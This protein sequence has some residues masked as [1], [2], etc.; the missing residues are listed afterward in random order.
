MTT[1]TPRGVRANL[2]LRQ[3]EVGDEAALLKTQE[4]LTVAA[5]HA[6][7]RHRSG[8]LGLIIVL[9]LLG[10]SLA[11]PLL[12][13]HDPLAM[14]T[15][16]RFAPPSAQYPMGAD[17]FGRDIFSRL[18]YGGRVAFMVSSISIALATIVGVTL[19]AVAGYLQGWFD[20]VSMRVLDAI[21]AFPAILLAIVILAV[22]GPGILNAMLAVAIV[23]I[24]AFARLARANVLVEKH[25]EYVTAARAVGATSARILFRAI[26]PNSL[27]TI[28]VRVTVAF[29]G[30][31]LLESS[32]SFL[33]L[34]VP[35]PAPSWGSML[36]IGRTYMNYAPWYSIAPGLAIMFLVLGVYLLGDGLRDVLDPRRQKS[37]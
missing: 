27:A 24:P 15:G 14:T 19:G 26:L 3:V 29:A 22:L 20:A 17:E 16:D 28:I 34:G 8:M 4:S 21:L 36:S 30:A 13:P 25:K 33:G 2:S 9:I 23:N 37:I 7:L 32:L 5:L 11:A 12:A 1:S 31:V 10:L 18:L 35:L 6:F